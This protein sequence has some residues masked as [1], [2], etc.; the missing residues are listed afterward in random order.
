MKEN[1][2]VSWHAR[3]KAKSSAVVNGELPLHSMELCQ[4]ISA[5]ELPYHVYFCPTMEIM[6]RAD[7][8][9]PSTICRVVVLS[10]ESK[11]LS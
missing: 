3:V 11:G 7:A 1:I 5:E 9:V 8:E 6:R 4:F 2:R 10:E